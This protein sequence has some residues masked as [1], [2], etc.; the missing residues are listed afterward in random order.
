MFV[1][2][3]RP[4][5]QQVVSICRALSRHVKLLIMDEPSSILDDGEVETLF[6][7]VRKLAADGVGVIYISH[8]LDEIQRIGDRVTVLSDGARSPP[9]CRPT[10]RA[11]SWSRR[12]SAASVDQLYPDAREGDDR[13]GRCSTS[14]ASR[15]APARAR[16]AAS[17]SAPARSSGSAGSS[18]P[19]APS[20]CA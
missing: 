3:L 10:R 6:G 14:T 9:A 18:A 4:A 16:S 20:C 5:A 2:T 11:P 7:V 8:R 1:R 15:G 17:R 13:R 12:W 19:A